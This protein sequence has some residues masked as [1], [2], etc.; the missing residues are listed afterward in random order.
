MLAGDFTIADVLANLP[1]FDGLRTIE[2]AMQSMFQDRDFTLLNGFEL[3]YIGTG[4]YQKEVEK[5]QQMQ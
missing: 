4:K 2:H 3:P 5:M 1:T